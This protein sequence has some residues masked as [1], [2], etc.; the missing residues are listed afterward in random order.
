MTGLLH[1]WVVIFVIG[2]GLVAIDAISHTL[3]YVNGVPA[4]GVIGAALILLVFSSMLNW[5]FKEAWDQRGKT[6]A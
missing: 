5:L 3:I 1:A 2:I 6:N 4:V